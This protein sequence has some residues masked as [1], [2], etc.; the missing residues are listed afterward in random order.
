MKTRMD[1]APRRRQ[2]PARALTTLEAEMV[3]AK[4]ALGLPATAPV[5][6]C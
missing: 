5:C 6:S 1:Q 4:G 2:V 3:R